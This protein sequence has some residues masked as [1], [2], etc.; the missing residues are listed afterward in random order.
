MRRGRAYVVAKIGTGGTDASLIVGEVRAEESVTVGA[1]C[2]DSV[3]AAF[4][5]TPVSGLEP[6]ADAASIDLSPE[7]SCG[8][9]SFFLSAAARA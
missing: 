3:L 7:A 4:I 6:F 5:G 2:C 1:S 9:V 8:S